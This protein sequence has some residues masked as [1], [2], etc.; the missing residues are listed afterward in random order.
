M[1]LTNVNFN[2]VKKRNKKAGLIAI[3]LLSIIVVS[4][5][6]ASILYDDG[7][8]DSSAISMEIDE[9]EPNVYRSIASDYSQEGLPREGTAVEVRT[10]GAGV[11]T[12]YPI[13]IGDGDDVKLSDDKY[14]S[15][16][17]EE[18]EF[19]GYFNNMVADTLYNYN[20]FLNESES[21]LEKILRP[22]YQDNEGLI[23][24]DILF[25][26]GGYYPQKELYQIYTI[27]GG[28]IEEFDIQQGVG[29]FDGWTF[30]DF[31]PSY[32]NFHSVYAYPSYI[33]ELNFTLRLKFADLGDPTSAT[34]VEYSIKLY[35]YWA[36]KWDTYRQENTSV[37]TYA[38]G[39]YQDDLL[40]LDRGTT[41]FSA[42]FDPVDRLT[43]LIR[44]GVKYTKRGA[45]EYE[46]RYQEIDLDLLEYSVKSIS[47]YATVWLSSDDPEIPK[48]DWRENPKL[49]IECK[50]NLTSIQADDV[51]QASVLGIGPIGSGDLPHGYYDMGVEV[52]T[53]CVE[54]MYQENSAP[55]VIIHFLS[56]VPVK[57]DIDSIL[58]TFYHEHTIEISNRWYFNK[59]DSD[60]ITWEVNVT[61]SLTSIDAQL[62]FSSD[63]KILEINTPYGD[64]AT[65][66][67]DFDPEDFELST[68]ITN[69]FGHGVYQI[70]A[71]ASNYIEEASI[72]DSGYDPIDDTSYTS[73]VHHYCKIKDFDELLTSGMIGSVTVEFLV[74]SAGYVYY[75][76]EDAE[77]IDSLK[78]MFNGQTVFNGSSV[79]VVDCFWIWENGI[80]VGYF[81]GQFVMLGKADDPP[82]V[83]I[84]NPERE[85]RVKDD[86]ILYAAI[87]AVDP[88]D[89]TYNLDGSTS[90]IDMDKGYYDIFDSVSPALQDYVYYAD[91]PV[92]IFEHE[93]NHFITVNAKE[94]V[95]SKETSQVVTVIIDKKATVIIEKIALAYDN[96]PTDV[97]IKFDDDIMLINIYLDN[98]RIGTL[99]GSSL[100]SNFKIPRITSGT[101][102]LKVEVRDETGNWGSDTGSFFVSQKNPSL[103]GT[104]GQW[105]GDFFKILGVMILSLMVSGI[106]VVTLHKRRTKQDHCPMGQKWNG[107]ECEVAL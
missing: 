100:S 104:L 8:S 28:S 51:I 93:T 27:R 79:G 33:D 71:T 48:E 39:I 50:S 17:T 106:A 49:I 16:I 97:D 103:F 36:D 44:I 15:V 90:D 12:A 43:M 75:Y 29:Y 80:N 46:G 58:F 65:K 78:E 72:S 35:N 1:S 26:D 14:F 4:A 13:Y 69:I 45:D 37:S 68:E 70:I 102:F 54:T 22:A 84:F 85:E 87:I 52:P 5:S 83:K 31:A 53:D 74:E 61:T 98:E 30:E 89:V 6:L 77:S 101:Y 57:I 23:T 107:K 9:E 24:A 86:E 47:Q 99:K 76:D 66:A 82:F 64:D 42:Y 95:N 56:H 2:D 34:P 20:G 105:F 21:T 41:D 73:P 94:G 63:Y 11:I 81:K 55:I 59:T 91:I 25:E 60:E 32:S 7:K 62:T 18:E 92:G 10:Q 19:G 38:Q 67:F 3:I 96:E 88:E 40:E